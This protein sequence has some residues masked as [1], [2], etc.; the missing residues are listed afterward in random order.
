MEVF[1]LVLIIGVTVAVVASVAGKRDT[2]EAWQQAARRLGLQYIPAKLFGGPEIV[3][4]LHHCRVRVDTHSR[5]SESSQT[6]TRYRVV[7]PWA[8]GLGLKL[9]PQRPWFG[10]RKLLGAQDIELG[11]AD[12]D[13]NVVVKGSNTA[14]ITAFLTPTRRALVG[15]FLST[16]DGAVIEDSEV[17]WE[18]RGTERSPSTLVSV[19][20]RM[21]DLAHHFTTEHPERETLPADA[22]P[23]PEPV[24]PL[25][26]EDPAPEILNEPAAEPVSPPMD[27]R[28]DELAGIAAADRLMDLPYTTGPGVG[29]GPGT[30]LPELIH[31][32]FGPDRPSYE[33]ERIFRERYQ[34]HAVLWVGK[35]SRVSAFPFDL[36]FGR[37]RGTKAELDIY[38]RNSPYGARTIQAI[39]QLPENA[40]AQLRTRTGT[41]LT[42][43]GT[44]V[45]CDSFMRKVWVAQGRILD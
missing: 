13:A 25:Q 42:F 4:T 31:D 26:P 8:L 18:A 24:Q 7:Y 9:T 20:E 23:R 16:L 45:R 32:L 19:V 44:L 1:V 12:F 15:R 21:V 2:N 28:H 34:N 29:T 40:L 33:V 10:V 30:Q 36:V 3:G 39:V 38:Q 27:E 11:D 35:L 17:R 22:L 5:G 41:E 6:Y 43:E 37:A 14:Q